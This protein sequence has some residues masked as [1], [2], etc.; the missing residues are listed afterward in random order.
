MNLIRDKASFDPH[1]KL[2]RDKMFVNSAEHPLFKPQTTSIEESENLFHT[3]VKF[4]EEVLRPAGL[5]MSGQIKGEGSMII[6]TEQNQDVGVRC[7]ICMLRR[8][9]NGTYRG[10]VLD[11]YG[12][13]MLFPDTIPPFE[14]AI[15]IHEVKGFRG[16]MKGI[17]STG[18]WPECTGVVVIPS[19]TLIQQNM[20]TPI[21]L[22]KWYFIASERAKG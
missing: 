16:G 2:K 8:M 6:A 14:Y 20:M 15:C 18:N 1:V 5:M 17:K 3:Q 9:K 7:K 12:K 11:N 13:Q 22:P 10:H 19:Y 4:V 21:I